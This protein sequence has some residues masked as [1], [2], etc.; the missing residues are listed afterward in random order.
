[1]ARAHAISG[2]RAVALDNGWRLALSAAGACADPGQAG[3]L[4]DWIAAPVPGTAAEAL[5]RAGRS[6]DRLGG[7]DVWYRREIEGQG[8]RTLKF[9][10]LAGLA[11]VWLDDRQILT[12]RSMFIGHEVEVELRGQH[13]LWLCFRA[14]DPELERKA[15]RARWRPRMIPRQGLRMIRTTLMGRMP[16]WTPP[17]EAVGPW[18]AVTCLD[19]S[20]LGVVRLDI[21]SGFENGR[22]WLNA[23]VEFDRAVV[24][25]VLV[26]DGRRLALQP[27]GDG[28]FGGRMI[29]DGIAPWW[30][31]THGAQ[32]LYP[33]SLKV[34]ADEIDLGRTGFRDI[35]VDRGADGEGFQLLVNGVPVFC[36]GAGWTSADA[37]SLPGG[38]DDY[39]PWLDLARQAGMN[40]LRMSGTGAYESHAFYELCDELGLLVWQDFMFANF[41]YPAADPGFA[42]EAATEAGQ[43]LSAIQLSPCL[44]V[45][46]GGSEALQQAAMMGLKPEALAS[47]LHDDILPSAAQAWRPDVPYVVNSPSAG[48][49]P[50]VVN[51]GIGHYYGVGAYCRPLEDARRAEVRFA[52]ECLAF[53]NV[54]QAPGLEG[55]LAAPGINDPAWKAGVPRDLGA[56]WDFDDV[57]DHY[58]GVV[59]GADPAK[60]RYADP[61]LY[62]DLSR[63]VTGEVMEQ[64]FA[65]W[66]RARS[67]CAGGLVWTFQDLMPG[68]GWGMIDVTGEPK[69]CWY[70]LKRAFRPVQVALTDEGVNGLAVH[71]TNETGEDLEVELELTCLRDGATPVVSVRKTLTLAARGGQE[72]SAYGLIGRFFDITYAYR[73]GPPGHDATVVRLRDADGG[74]LAE[75]FHYPTGRSLHPPGGVVS[76][77]IFEDARGW[78]MTLST[79]RLLQSVHIEDDNFRP[80]DDWFDLAPG[81]P[82]Q[83]RLQARREGAKPSGE[84]T[85]PGGRV[86]L[87]YSAD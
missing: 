28:G 70:A 25:P 49:L 64:V 3:A 18:R 2:Q 55:R 56:S 16:G 39:A 31:H 20:P 79:D 83:V 82:K 74:V 77:R 48:P 61:S 44:A 69:P 43:F 46:C 19:P 4:E 32:P 34:G 7:L 8:P 5:R 65:E 29:L 50:F 1:L 45:L 81:E 42:R 58:L 26:C 9:D 23:A 73:F 17:V 87:T 24:P 40:M 47:A 78:V 59:Y 33:V 21:T 51:K 60:L 12:S 80:D 68:A 35:A 85:V 38:R 6:Y 37:V 41:D 15:P 57:R 10:G 36:R 11:E 84:I 66:R 67:P 76:A 86:L 75:A 22:G 30:P 52:A 62:L 27:R 54:P 72:V 71:L 63:A 13:A 53:A 14:L